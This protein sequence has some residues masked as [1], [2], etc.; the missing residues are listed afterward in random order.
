MK[1]VSCISAR[2][3]LSLLLC[4]ALVFTCEGT[5]FAADY[6]FLQPCSLTVYVGDRASAVRAYHV[7]YENNL[8]LSLDDLSAALDGSKKQFSFTNLPIWIWNV[9][10]RN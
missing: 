10:L 6:H 3:V 4:A 1:S 8:Y 5:A 7:N 2:S 9:I